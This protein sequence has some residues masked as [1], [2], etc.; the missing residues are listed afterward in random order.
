M[1]ILGLDITR[2]SKKNNEML[3]ELQTRA[4]DQL[5]VQLG[6]FSGLVP[7]FTALGSN[8]MDNEAYASAIR[9]N[10]IH[11]SKVEFSSVRITEDGEQKHDYKHLD[12]LLQLRPNPLNSAAVFWERVATY[13]YHYNNAF[14]YIELDPYGDIKAL[15]APD[16][17]TIQFSKLADGEVLLR[18]N[19]NGVEVEYPY[20]MVAHIAGNVTREPLF[21]IQNTSI[22]RVLN[23]INTNYQGIENA[24]ITS[25]YIRFIGEL[26]TKLGDDKLEEKSRQFTERYLTV[27]KNRDPVGIIFS[28]SSY[29]LTPVTTNGQ[30]TANYAE[31]KQF[32]EVVYKFLGCPEAVIAGTANEDEM[33]AYYE[34]TPSVF[35]ERVAQ[36]LT[37]KVFTPGEYSTGNRI[38][39]SDR[40]LQY[41]SMATRLQIFNA[42]RELGAFTLGTLGD[43]LG[44]PVPHKQRNKIVVSQNYQGNKGGGPKPDGGDGGD[45]PNKGNNG[46]GDSNNGEANKNTEG[47]ESNA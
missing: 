40:R 15:W 6:N 17:A 16:P 1:R 13:Y 8:Y 4:R 37:A 32:N 26:V 38:V 33:V 7:I 30:K 47:G 43:L 20:S 3:S 46:D 5:S 22:K 11:C 14:I 29:K 12:K 36:E 18:F 35:F 23:L 31:M 24:I 42:G 19:L 2:R 9:T 21:G 25:A 39:F 44:L 34:R 27:N 10:A 41:R 45:D 28:D